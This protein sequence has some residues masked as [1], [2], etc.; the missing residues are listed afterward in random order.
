MYL[1]LNEESPRHFLMRCKTT[2]SSE[3]KKFIGSP[4]TEGYGN[5]TLSFGRT[6]RTTQKQWLHSNAGDRHHGQNDKSTVA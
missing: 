2:F 1:L 4:D 5:N 6:Y 3:V